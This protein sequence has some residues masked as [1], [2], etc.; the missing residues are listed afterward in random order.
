MGCNTSPWSDSRWEVGPTSL[1]SQTHPE[2]RKEG[3]VFWATFLVTWSGAALRKE[4]HNCIFKSEFLTPQPIWTTTQPGLQ[5]LEMAQSL[6]GQPKTGC[7]T[8]FHY[9][10]FISKY[11]HLRHAI[12]IR[13]SEIWLVIS[14]P[15][16]TSPHV[17]RNVAQSTRPSLHMLE[18]LG[19]RLCQDVWGWGC[20]STHPRAV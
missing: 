8:S 16:W 17:A 11:N 5:K 9:F 3:L 15:R 4:C 2:K 19:T 14:N 18:G 6:L 12:I 13:S 1:S 7:E 20:R 10:R